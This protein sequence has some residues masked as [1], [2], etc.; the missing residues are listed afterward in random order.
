MS[1]EALR[2]RLQWM[3]KRVKFAWAKYYEQVNQR[4]HDA[5]VH[6]VR[7]T[8]TGN[9]ASIPEHIK[10]ELRSMA[11]ALKK[12]WEC[13]ICMGFIEEDALEITNCG[14]YYC[15]E[16]LGGWKRSEKERGA[17]KWKC[18][19]CNRKHKFTDDDE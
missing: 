10:E 11:S 5:H 7:V 3:Q 1:E 18:G 19:M 14:H 9:D 12:Q 17:D 15:K 6:V 8:E 13:P 16:C 4:L 2:N